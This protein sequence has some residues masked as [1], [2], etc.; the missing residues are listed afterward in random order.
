M[1]GSFTVIS[2]STE[3][4]V[5]VG[6][7]IQEFFN[8]QESL[9]VNRGAIFKESLWQHFVSIFVIWLFGLFVWGIPFILIIIGVKGF[10]FG[11]TIGFMVH[12]YRFGGFLFSLI[13]IIPQSIIYVPCYIGMVI[14]ALLFS[15]SGYGK[16]RIH[17][18]KEQ[19]KKRF[20]LYTKKM[21]IGLI[22]LL[23]GSL[24]ETFIAP[25]LFPLFLWI[26]R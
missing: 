26:F 5:D 24:M 4:K 9:S 3:Q 20:A 13:C 1:A 18:S 15:L 11:F 21:L 22:I 2:L 19:Q 6:N 23:I 14:I 10:Y 7:F 12:H 25:L 8:S 17:Y 16:N